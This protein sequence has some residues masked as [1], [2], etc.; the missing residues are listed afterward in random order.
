MCHVGHRITITSCHKRKWI[1]I[2]WAVHL[3]TVNV[4]NVSV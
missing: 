1:F 4:Q 3:Q 2:V